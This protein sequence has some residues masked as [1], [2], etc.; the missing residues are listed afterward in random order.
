MYIFVPHY[1]R[2]VAKTSFDMDEVLRT[3]ALLRLGRASACRG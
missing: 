3:T 1:S 2:P